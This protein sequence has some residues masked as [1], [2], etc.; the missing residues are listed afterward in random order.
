ML[1]SCAVTAQLICTFV[2]AYVKTRFSH[3]GANLIVN[4][5]VLGRHKPGILTLE[6]LIDIIVDLKERY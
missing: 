6:V 3:D 4:L 2:L 5:E 1:I